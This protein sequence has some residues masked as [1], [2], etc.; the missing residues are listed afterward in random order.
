MSSETLIIAAV[1]VPLIGAIL[2]WL[3]GRNANLRET[4]TIIISIITFL[5]VATL[6]RDVAS[7]EHPSFQE[8]EMLPGL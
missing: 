6:F 5:I 7:G 4:V 8:I 2:I 1:L 3:T